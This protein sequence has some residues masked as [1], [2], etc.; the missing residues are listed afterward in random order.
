MKS[1]T[2][3]S[4]V[5][6]LAT[7]LRD[8]IAAGRLSGT[9]PGVN[10]IVETL[11]VGTETAIGAM[12]ELKRDGVI[13]S[14]GPRRGNRILG[15]G[16]NIVSSLR[17]KILLFSKGDETNRDSLDLMH[18]MQLTGHDPEFA[19]RHLWSMGMDPKR[20]ARFVKRN[21]ADAW[22]VI[23][24]SREILEWFA[25]QPLHSFAM[26]GGFRGL[27]LAGAKP[28][29]IEA[30]R[31]AVRR[32]VE[33]GH[34]RIVKLVLSDRV[35]PEPGQL[36][37]AFIAEL[38]SLG[39]ATSINYNLPVW[40]GNPSIF[41]KRLDALFQHTPPTA[42][43]IDAVSLFHAAR[44]HLA[45]QGILAPRDVSLICCDP[46]PGFEWMEPKIAHI[47]WSFKPLAR[48]AVR[49]LDNVASG[50]NDR[51]QTL[52]KASFIDGGTIGPPKG[53]IHRFH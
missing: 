16:E 26:L 43:F 42:I 3:K 48:R 24:G 23:A 36:E 35:L 5:E 34:R 4:A 49:W 47:H 33:L 11:G 27:T 25:G 28:D 41:Y 12:A 6:Q 53:R 15:P 1:F 52:S 17:V 9:M 38:E 2:A 50:K 32:L 29:K 39:I 7:H 10:R 30:Q 31:Q 8:E 37:R 13:E 22:V 51:R 21:P 46:D 20:V 45:R 40:G 19:T 44:D 18:H 14:L